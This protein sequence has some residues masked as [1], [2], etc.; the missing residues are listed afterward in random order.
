VLKSH[1]LDVEERGATMLSPELASWFAVQ[2]MPQHEYKVATQLRY[3]GQEEFLPSVASRRR[4]SDRS[5]IVDRPLFPGYVFCRLNRSSFGTVLSTP[6]VYRIVSFGGQPYPVS[7]DEMESL[8]Q[9]LDSGRDVK[10]VP[11]LTLGQ[12]V[13]IVSGPLQGLTG[14]I[15]RFKTQNRLVVSMD[16]LM[17][18]IAIEVALSEIRELPAKVH[19]LPERCS[20]AGPEA[21]PGSETILPTKSTA[22][23]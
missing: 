15:T 23:L 19:D 21:I 18:S 4:W 3:K 16:M 2:V 17:R 1:N 22:A 9:I 7:D 10:P 5:K 8:H 11:Y 12:K 6:G 13:Q 14:V 20:A